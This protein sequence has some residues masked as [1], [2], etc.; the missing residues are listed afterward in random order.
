MLILAAG[1]SIPYLSSVSP[2]CD[3]VIYEQPLTGRPH[4]GEGE[5]FLKRRPI[6]FLYEKSHNSETKSR[7]IDL[8]VGNEPSLRGPQTGQNW[9]CMAKLGF[10]GQKLRFGAQKKRA[11]PYC[12]HA[13]ASTGK[14]KLDKKV[15]L[16]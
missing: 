6:F 9:G 14:F 8:K 4:S 12:N 15:K 1:G 2:S 5:D 13:L 16:N 10:L 3:D 7:K 11:L